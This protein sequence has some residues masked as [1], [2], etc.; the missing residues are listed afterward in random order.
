MILLR[1]L[2]VE[3]DT[4][5]EIRSP[6]E[7]LEAAVVRRELARPGSV[8]PEIY[9]QLRYVLSFSKLTVVRAQDGEDVELAGRIAP[10][11]WRVAEALKPFVEGDG[12]GL[13]GVTSILPD[14]LAATLAEQSKILEQGE[15]DR[16]SLEAEICTRQLVLVAG[17]GGGSGYG[18][19]GGYTLLNRHGLQPEL[20]AGTSMGALMGVFRA[21]TEVFDLA[22]MVAAANSL[23]WAKVFRV[24][25][26]D[27][28]YGV[29]ATLRLY[30]RAAIGHLFEL[31]D[32]TP[33][34]L[35]DLEL[36]MLVVVTGVTVDGL[37]HDLDYYEHFLDDMAGPGRIF[38][39]SRLARVGRIAGIFKE[40]ASS[41]DNLREIVFG[42]DEDT[43]AVDVIDAV[44]FSSAIP[45]LIHYDIY[46]EDDRM[47][48]LLDTLYGQTGITR[49]LEGGIVN[50][51]PCKPAYAEVMRGRVGRR[52]PFVFA[53]DCFA[54]R[55]RSPIF[56]PVQQIVRPNVT[57]NH[58]YAH[59]VFNM[60]RRLNPLNLVPSMPD[61]S[62]A[63]SWTIEEL[64][65]DMAFVTMMCAPISPVKLGREE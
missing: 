25:D 36:P 18:Y 31:E 2:R 54:P 60:K 61:I 44:G 57:R 38:R 37:K 15:I 12:D 65:P 24:L 30:L 4:H 33:M 3:A 62:K 11:R 48:R 42:A 29:P 59:H 9:N 20:V 47:R 53:M 39:R 63:M 14:L 1:K 41:P 16:E 51:L 23:S 35:Q 26:L 8:S 22:P 21:R 52:N 56:L 58:A 13:S 19:P 7:A 40:L 34:T 27:S 32:G 64:E 46:R 45:G 17:G 28:R 43:R 49:L 55:A 50:N 10:H 6:I 5:L